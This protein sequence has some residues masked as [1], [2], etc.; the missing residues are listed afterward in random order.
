MFENKIK[1]LVMIFILS[2]L[3]ITFMALPLF[4]HNEEARVL[5][6]RYHQY[7]SNVSTLGF[8]K[9]EPEIYI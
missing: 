5:I 9:N 4:V 8:F 2:S 7:Q 1:F 3:L 6:Y